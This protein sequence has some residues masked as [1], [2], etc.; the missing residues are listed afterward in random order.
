MHPIGKIYQVNF[1]LLQ[2]ALALIIEINCK[3]E[4]YFNSSC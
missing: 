1:E 3:G 2:E 4:R